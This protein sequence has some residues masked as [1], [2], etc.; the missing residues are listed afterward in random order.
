MAATSALELNGEEIDGQKVRVT[1][2][3]AKKNTD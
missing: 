3:G 2:R 1:A